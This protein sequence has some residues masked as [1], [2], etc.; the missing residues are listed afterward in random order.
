MFIKY[1]DFYPRSP[2]GERR[3]N[4]RKERQGQ[5]ISIHA[6]LAES[7]FYPPIKPLKIG[8]SIHALLAESDLSALAPEE[9]PTQFLSTLSLRRATIH[10]D[11]Y[12]LHCVISIHALLAESDSVSSVIN[13]V[14][15]D[16][17]PRSP[18]GER[19]ANAVDQILP[20]HIS[21]HALLAESD[22]RYPYQGRQNPISIHALLAE[23]DTLRASR[24]HPAGISIHALL[25]ESDPRKNLVNGV[26]RVISIHAL[27]A[28]S[29]GTKKFKMPV[30]AYFYPRSPCGERRHK[31]TE[32]IINIHFYPRSPCGERPVTRVARTPTTVISIH[33]LLAES[34]LTIMLYDS[35]ALIFLSTLSLRRATDTLTDDVSPGG[36]FYPRSPCGERLTNVVSSA[37]T[38]DFYP[39]SP[40]GERRYVRSDRPNFTRISIHALLA[41]SDVTSSTVIVI[42]SKNFYPRSPCGERRQVK[43]TCRAKIS[44]SIHALLAESDNQWMCHNTKF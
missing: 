16:F 33:A 15:N 42:L 22:L 24:Q 28:E 37:G 36:N 23:S 38:M 14:I 21:I 25:A 13:N 20:G 43:Q 30:P 7:D 35:S 44:I 39:R 29:D 41:E 1:H 10:Y 17:Y 32:L 12:N 8:I 9:N 6:L 31:T 3:A 19:Q 4:S 5:R 27:L 11:N 26:C 34:D 18:C 40:C 2:C